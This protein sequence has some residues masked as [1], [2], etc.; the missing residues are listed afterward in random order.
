[1][2]L[3]VT[4]ERYIAV[5]RPHQYRTISQTMSNTKRLLVY[6]IPVTSIS[7]ALNIPKFMEVKLTESNGTNVVDASDTR[8]NP[9][10]IFYYTLSLIW[11]PTLTTGILPFFLQ[12]RQSRQILSG[13]QNEKRRSEFNLAITLLSIVLMHLLCNALRVVLG[14]LVV[15][16]VDV[17]VNCIKEQGHYIPPL[18]IMCLE[19]VAHLLVIFNFSSNFLIYCSVSTQF[20]AALS[21]LCTFLRQETEGN[22][23]LPTLS[24]NNN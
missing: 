20:K 14:V 13:R 21:K 15:A 22:N 8:S 9:T 3:A 18:W 12:I 5:C 17:Q 16:L 10:Y 4:V 19:S 23:Q 24:L 2:T 7:F 11:H 1:M 6:I